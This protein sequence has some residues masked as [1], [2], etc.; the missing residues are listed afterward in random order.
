ML[1]HHR[2]DEVLVFGIFL[3]LVLGLDVPRLIHIF[4]SIRSSWVSRT[5]LDLP[6]MVHGDLTYI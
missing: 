2:F 3:E 6:Y 4:L 5:Q 1:Y